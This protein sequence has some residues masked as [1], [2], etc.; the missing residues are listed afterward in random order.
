LSTLALE[1]SSGADGGRSATLARNADLALLALAV[2][3]FLLAELPI[4]G[5]LAAAAGW[6]AQRAVQ[7]ATESRLTQAAERK[8]ALGL[9][10]GSIVARLWIVTLAVLIVGLAVDDQA[11]LAAAVLAAAL[12]TASL[13]GE[14]AARLAGSRGDG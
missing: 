12:V 14:G 8:T 1:P 13:A 5:F 4:A 10:G 9:I 6:I 2:P 7:R 11:G 3:I